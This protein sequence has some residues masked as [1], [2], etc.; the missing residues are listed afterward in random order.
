MYYLCLYS[1]IAWPR[2][3]DIR[4]YTSEQGASMRQWIE[5]KLR[6]VIRVHAT[7]GPRLRL[8]LSALHPDA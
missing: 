4:R 6:R 1:L 2:K 5:K 3:L 8:T 7:R